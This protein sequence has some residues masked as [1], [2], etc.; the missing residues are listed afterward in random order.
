MSIAHSIMLLVTLVIVLTTR[1]IA[2]DLS[3]VGKSGLKADHSSPISSPPLKRSTSMSFAH[4]FRSISE[5]LDNSSGKFKKRGTS[6]GNFCVIDDSIQ[7]APTTPAGMPKA[8]QTISVSPVVPHDSPS[9]N[10]PCNE[11][12]NSSIDEQTTNRRFEDD[13]MDDEFQMMGEEVHLVRNRYLTPL[14]NTED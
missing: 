10:E 3:A 14:S 5:R 7:S 6:M 13:G 12:E 11:D 9:P 4:S 1:G 2:L 8:W